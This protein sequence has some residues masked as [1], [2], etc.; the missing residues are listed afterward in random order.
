MDRKN[1]KPVHG[2]AITIQIEFLQAETIIVIRRLKRFFKAGRTRIIVFKIIKI[3]NLT[4]KLSKIYYV[5]E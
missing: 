4:G 1:V 3:N 2:F 5:E